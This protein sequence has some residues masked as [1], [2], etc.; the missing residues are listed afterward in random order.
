MPDHN[1]GLLDEVIE[2][3]LQLRKISLHVFVARLCTFKLHR[4][5]IL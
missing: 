1:C 4:P 5:A 3:A 2:V